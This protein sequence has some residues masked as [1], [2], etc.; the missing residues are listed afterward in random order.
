MYIVPAG[1]KPILIWLYTGLVMVFCMIAIGGITRLTESGLS[2]TEWNVVMGSVPPLSE[3]AWQTEF[4]KYRE[5]PEFKY[6]NNDFT[7]Q[8]FKSIY[9]WEFMHRLWGRLIGMVFFI[10]FCF[11]I[12]KK[13]FYRQSVGR[14]FFI[15]L[16]GGFQGFLG[17]YMVQSGLVNEPRVSHYRL[18]AHLLTALLSMALIWWFIQ[19]IRYENKQSDTPEQKTYRKWMMGFFGLFIL[20][21][22]YGAFVAGLDAGQYYNTWPKMDQYWIP[23]SQMQAT[24][25][26]DTLVENLATIQFIHRSVAGILLV[27]VSVLWWKSRKSG[28]SSLQKQGFTLM[29]GCIFLQFLLGVFTIL[30]HVPVWLG[31]MHQLGAVLLMLASLF[32]AHQLWRPKSKIV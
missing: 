12:W 29:T 28:L 20:Q 2:I 25:I 23:A 10:P 3:E 16:L 18:A 6:K 5:S 31:V 7:L 26:P 1:R 17:W 13:W 24:P 8:Q 19:D 22:L 30:F 27:F 32:T 15:F 11:F 9:W 4:S 21:V 14:L